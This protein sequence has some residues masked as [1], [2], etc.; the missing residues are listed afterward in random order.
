MKP[1]E[2]ACQ[3]IDQMLEAAGSNI[4]DY[5]DINLVTSFGVAGRE[6]LVGADFAD[7]LLFVDRKAIGVGEAKHEGVTLS[8]VSEQTRAYLTS[9]P[10]LVLPDQVFEEKMSNEPIKRE[11][12]NYGSS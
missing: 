9:M 4:R 11:R 2:K 3:Q 7:Y 10:A 8:R 5:R 12:K 6:Y 1:V